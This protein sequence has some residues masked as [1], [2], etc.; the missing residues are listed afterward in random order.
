MVL[1]QLQC[2]DLWNKTAANIHSR[3]LTD[4]HAFE[5][6]FQTNFLFI[7]PRADLTDSSGWLSHLEASTS[8]TLS[9]LRCTMMF[10][11]TKPIRSKPDTSF[12]FSHKGLTN[13]LLYSAANW[14]C[15]MSHSFQRCHLKHAVRKWNTYVQ[16]EA[17]AT[18][19][20]GQ[21][22]Q[23]PP[24]DPFLPRE[25]DQERSWEGWLFCCVWIGFLRAG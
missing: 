1:I 4:V 16:C 11:L 9:E 13:I 14:E 21:P 6:S 3:Q 15:K 20:R 22:L 2:T 12:S 23:G 7:T 24:F 17:T 10:N 19:V 8:W 25:G 5:S 18:C